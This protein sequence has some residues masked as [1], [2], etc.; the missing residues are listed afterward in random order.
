MW[1]CC[2]YDDWKVAEARLETT[3][4]H[5]RANFSK[6]FEGFLNLD[7][8]LE[9]MFVCFLVLSQLSLHSMEM[10]LGVKSI[11]G[12]T[13]RGIGVQNKSHNKHLKEA[14]HGLTFTSTLIDLS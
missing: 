7:V 12:R 1:A 14:S 2:R 4:S 10:L 6:P 5:Y 3:A 8:N 11:V 9:L 13:E